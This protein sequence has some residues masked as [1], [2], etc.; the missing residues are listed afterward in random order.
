[1]GALP[2]VNVFGRGN[3]VVVNVATQSHMG[4]MVKECEKEG[5]G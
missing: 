5:G 1:M 3:S 4:I 2:V